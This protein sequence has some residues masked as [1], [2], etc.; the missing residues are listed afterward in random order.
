MIGLNCSI[1]Q[2]AKI[3]NST[4]L[5]G[6]TVERSTTLSACLVGK[7]AHIGEGSNLQNVVIDFNANVP[8]NTVQTG[9]TF[10]NRTEEG[11]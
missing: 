10:P 2:G 6:V 7:N 11:Q 5:Q 9:G 4:L 3:K 8:K 1:E